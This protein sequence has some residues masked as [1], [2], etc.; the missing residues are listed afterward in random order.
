MNW[1]IHRCIAIL[2]AA[3]IAG[4]PFA[5]KAGEKVQ[6][7]TF[8]EDD[9]QKNMASK[10]Y[11]LKHTKAADVAPFIR[12]AVV[13]YCDESNVSTVEDTERNRQ[14]LIV[15]T[16]IDMIEHVDKLVAALDRPAKVAKASNITG[17]GIAYGIY[18]P[19]FRSSQSMLDIIVKGE[20]SSGEIDS[21][22]RFDSKRNMFYFKDTPATVEDI[23]NKLAWLDKPVPQVRLEMKVYQVRDSDLKDIGIDYLA[24]KNGPGLNLFS[25]GY[26]ALNVRTAEKLVE[27]LGKSVDI[28]GNATWGFG[29]FYTAPAFDLSFLRILQQNGKA[30]ISS[31]ASV[32]IT[33]NRD[34]EFKVNFA[35]EYQNISKDEYHASSISVGGDSS[36]S[37]VIMN[38]VITAGKNGCVNFQC[39]LINNNVVERN[40]FGAELTE[41]ENISARTVIDFNKEQLLASWNRTGTVEQTVG[42]PFLCEIPVLKYLFGTTT[43][44][45]E[46]NRF[47]VTVRA[48]PVVF[49]ENMAP[50]TIA[51]FDKLANK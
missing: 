51:E 26:E 2:A 49:N 16:G 42:I 46:T 10:I 23:K 1:N 50:G 15:S 30:T 27:L 45:T 48:V 11:T 35:P 37:A 43:T 4:L 36:L 18:Q 25:A 32:I 24:W 39:E 33:N 12:S 38:P 9:A 8:I 22:V 31:S 13:R 7:I 19:Q 17:D 5:A 14:M 29:G 40:N 28:A 21:D 41:T 34:R 20:V 44:N 47:F 3:S 6:K